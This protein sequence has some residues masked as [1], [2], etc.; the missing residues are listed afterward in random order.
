VK[1]Q[2]E[3]AHNDELG[4]PPRLPEHARVI[5]PRV[6]GRRFPYNPK[7]SLGAERYSGK[8]GKEMDRLIKIVFVV[9]VAVAIVLAAKYVGLLS[10]PLSVGGQVV[11]VV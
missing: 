6:V 8:G 10:G 4:D 11:N 7:H 1:S 3:E 5:R 2:N 9:A